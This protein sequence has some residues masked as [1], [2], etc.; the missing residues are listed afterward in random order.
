MIALP[1][2][3]ITIDSKR[4]IYVDYKAISEHGL[5]HAKQVVAACAELAGES[6]C[7]VIADITRVKVGANR[8]ARDYYASEEASVHKSAMA[9]VVDSVFQRLLGNLFF[10]INRPPYPTKMFSNRD[11]AEAWALEYAD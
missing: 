11:K 2:A 10:R 7:P 5:E 6:R 9:M 3:D 1:I 4:I 8:E